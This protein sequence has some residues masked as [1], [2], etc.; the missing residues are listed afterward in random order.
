M[1]E[2]FPNPGE[3]E[4]LQDAQ[5]TGR[6]EGCEG[7]IVGSRCNESL[8]KSSRQ[9]WDCAETAAETFLKQINEIYSYK[10]PGPDACALKLSEYLKCRTDELFLVARSV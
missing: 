6:R 7:I 5:G 4:S 1:M 10:L 8:H 9:G 3:A 2:S